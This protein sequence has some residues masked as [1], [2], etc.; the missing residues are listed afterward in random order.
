MTFRPASFP[1]I[2]RIKEIVRFFAAYCVR[3]VA[4][5]VFR[6]I[7]FL[8]HGTK[9][10]ILFDS[11]SGRQYSCNTRAIYEYMLAHYRDSNVRYVWAFHD[12]DKFA[13]LISDP[14]T[15]LCRY[16]KLKYYYYCSISDAIIFN[17]A[18]SVATKKKQIRMQ[19]WHGGGCYKK[20][21]LGMNYNSP[22]RNWFSRVRMKD[23]THFVSSSEFFTREVIRKQ[24]SFTGTV[25][26]VGMPR[27]DVLV[28]N[29]DTAA[30]IVALKRRIGVPEDRFLVLYAPTYDELHL[31]NLETIDIDL[32]KRAVKVR[33]GLDAFFLYRGHHYTAQTELS[34]YDMD[35]SAYPDMVDILRVTDML[36]TNYSSSIWDYSFTGRPCILFVPDLRAYEEYRG[37][38]KDI[39]EWGFP[40]C[41]TNEQLNRII[42]TF[43]MESFSEAMRRHHEDLGSYEHGDAT[44]QICDYLAHTM[45][46]Q[47]A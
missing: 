1:L 21:G 16:K 46:I 10:T 47:T 29:A 7:G 40:I 39:Q 5:L 31:D 36:I 8:F 38:D 19:T 45:G 27:N 20:I 34:G 30:E 12:P 15:L 42:R 43:D 35:L 18:W 37:F 13:S 44:K 11:M 9:K 14:N 32:V 41:E 2:Q 6:P 3:V 4:K 28:N 33:F 25:L 17:F 26:S 24:Y 22:V 23:I